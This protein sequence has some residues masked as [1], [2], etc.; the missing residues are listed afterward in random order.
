LFSFANYEA[1]GFSPFSIESESNEALGKM[2]NL[3]ASLQPLY[4]STQGKGKIKGVLLDKAFQDTSITMGNYVLNCKHDYTLSWTPGSKTE[5]WPLASAMI[6]QVNENQFYVAGTGVVITFQYKLKAA[7]H[8]GLLKA[9]EGSFEN[10]EWKVARH[11]N[12]DQTHQGRHINIPM[13]QIGIQRV[14]LYTYE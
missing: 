12:G 10:N 11:L 3:I 14:E 2:Y 7:L 6:M 1:I 8:V 4:S 9:E 5:V 13:S